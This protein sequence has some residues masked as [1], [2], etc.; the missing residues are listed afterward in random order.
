MDDTS[1]PQLQPEAWLDKHGDV[2]Y[3]YALA[4]T[5]RRD[6]AQD[7]VQD[8]LLAAWQGQKSF[9]GGA[10]ER[11][12]LVGICRH[13]I[14]DHFRQSVRHDV[15]QTEAPAASSTEGDFFKPNGTWRDPPGTWDYEPLR[16]VEAEG[17]L[18]TLQ[19]CMA[20]LPSA[21]RECFELRE[22]AETPTE[23]ASDTLGV[24]L[25]HL[26]V[27]LHRARLNLRQCLEKHWFAHEESRS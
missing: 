17:F 1:S 10:S 22:L 11:T 5:G 3:R 13:K 21:Q 19:Q 7:L 9:N 4:R 6:L 15:G 23:E 8:T 26:Y 24:S 25:N 18:Q 16:M 2:L 27:L 20:S 12:W 14:Q